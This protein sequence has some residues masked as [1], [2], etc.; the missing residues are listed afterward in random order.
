MDMV[1]EDSSTGGLQPKGLGDVFHG[2]SAR[3]ALIRVVYVGADP[4][5]GKALGSF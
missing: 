3:G 2:G 1:G 4:C 5:M